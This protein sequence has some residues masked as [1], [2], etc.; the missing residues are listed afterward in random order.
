MDIVPRVNQN[1]TNATNV[2]TLVALEM[3]L[4]SNHVFFL[5]FFQVEQIKRDNKLWSNESLFLKEH[6]FIPV[7][8]DN[9]GSLPEDTVIV[10]SECVRGQQNTSQKQNGNADHVQSDTP[11]DKRTESV[12]NT[13]VESS[14]SHSGRLSKPESGKESALDFLSKYDSSIAQLKTNVKKMEQNAAY[15]YRLLY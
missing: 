10:G 4:M 7:T 15:V 13:A 6:V 11:T 12:H 5:F 2:S 3:F 8:R 14:K 1:V 9:S